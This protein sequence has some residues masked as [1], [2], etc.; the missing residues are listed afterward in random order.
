VGIFNS[1]AYGFSMSML[2]FHSRPWP[3]ELLIVDGKPNL[4]RERMTT[5][6]VL[7]GQLLIQLDKNRV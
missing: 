4:I 6:D 1:G 7:R 5:E 3:A 2:N